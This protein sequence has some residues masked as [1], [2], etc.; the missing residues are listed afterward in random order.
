MVSFCLFTNTSHFNAV[1]HIYLIPIRLYISCISR[2][3]KLCPWSEWSIIG[4]LKRENTCDTREETTVDA[5]RSLVGKAL[6]H[7]V[8]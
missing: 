4:G 2:L 7:L 5:F 1:V 3:S 6:N 8:K